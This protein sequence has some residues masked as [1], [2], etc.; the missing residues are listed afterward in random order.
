[1]VKSSG[2]KG[3]GGI[4][5]RSSSARWTRLHVN[6][7][8]SQVCH[9]GYAKELRCQDVQGCILRGCPVMSCNEAITA[10]HQEWGYCKGVGA[11]GPRGRSVVAVLLSRLHRY[12]FS[13]LTTE[14]PIV[15]ATSVLHICLIAP[16]IS[17]NACLKLV[18]REFGVFIPLYGHA[19]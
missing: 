2:L 10:P 9:L 17:V 15:I 1:M 11:A 19:T 4:N 5:N 8:R 18:G 16:I 6:G 3:D 14:E 12:C 7:I 13:G